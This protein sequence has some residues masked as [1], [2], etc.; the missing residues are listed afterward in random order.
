MRERSHRAGWDADSAND[1]I[2]EEGRA[3]EK[4]LASD[5]WRD[6]SSEIARAYV[7]P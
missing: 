4:K 2:G 5:E 6:V 7:K 1:N 3:G